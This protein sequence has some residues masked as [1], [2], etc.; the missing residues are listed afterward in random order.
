MRKS[1]DSSRILRL[2]QDLAPQPGEGVLTQ[3]GGGQG[4]NQGEDQEERTEADPRAD[5]VREERGVAVKALTRKGI[6]GAKV[7]AATRK[8]KTRVNQKRECQF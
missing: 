6:E 2:G 8:R 1:G 4:A 3:Q 5:M 7:E